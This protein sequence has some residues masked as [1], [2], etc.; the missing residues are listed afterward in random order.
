MGSKWDPTDDGSL[1]MK[2]YGQTDRQTER[3]SDRKTDNRRKGKMKED[4]WM[5]M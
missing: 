5:S 2:V 3:Q 4:V 1:E